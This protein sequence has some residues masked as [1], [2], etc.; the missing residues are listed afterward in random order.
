MAAEGRSIVVA[1]HDLSA[2]ARFCHRLLLLAEGRQVAL[3]TP[4]DVLT[5][6]RLAS[7]YGI[8]A[9]ISHIDGV[10]IVLPLHRLT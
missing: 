4:L 9:R 7:V 2:A 8:E 3:G 1:L 6:A 10:P 5:T